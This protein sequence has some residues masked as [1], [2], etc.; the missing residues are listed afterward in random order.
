MNKDTARFA[1]ETALKNGADNCRVTHVIGEIG[2]MS[3]LDGELENLQSSSARALQ[4]NIFVNGR[5]GVFGTNKIDKEDLTTFIKQCISSCRLLEPDEFYSLPD[6]SLYYDGKGEDLEICDPEF[7]R[8]SIKKKKEIAAECYDEINH[9]DKRV[10]SLANDFNETYMNQCILDSQGLEVE[11]SQSYYSTSCECTIRGN[12]DARPQNNWIEQ[13]IFLDELLPGSGKKAY[14]RAVAMINAEKIKSGKYNVVLENTVATKMIDGIIDA[15][16]G[17]AQYHKKTF[18]PDSL[19]KKIFPE[20]LSISDSPHIHR[21]IGASYFDTEGVA[22]HNLKIIENGIIANYLTGTYYSNKMKT[23]RTV[24][25]PFIL[26]FDRN[27]GIGEQ[28]ILKR[29]GKSIF[30]T[31]FNGG[32]N[33]P[34]TGDFSYG[35]E[36][37]LCENGEK[38]KAIKEM[39][40]SGNFISLWQNNLF[41]GN[42]PQKTS[43]WRIPTLAFADVDISGI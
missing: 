27:S 28:E 32:N 3:Y 42:D 36:G 1:L 37:F 29:T 18:L 41:I 30:I 34:I 39:N 24:P 43:L 14:E 8:H 11:E 5:Y 17:S 4:L 35:I 16:S 13:S 22:S 40:I 20:S 38:V 25:N 9:D 10:V 23:K 7:S 6:K 26:T 33:N 21:S 19:G 2:S 31:G 12:G 15:L